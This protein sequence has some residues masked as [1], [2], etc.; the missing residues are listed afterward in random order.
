M[1]THEFANCWAIH[2]ER[3]QRPSLRGW[4]R[5]E[6]EANEKMKQ[7]QAEDPEKANTNYWVIRMTKGEH[8]I[9]KETGFLPA[10]A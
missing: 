1:S 4:G 9:L 5:T 8:S 10:D 2:S 7:L 6:A 3:E